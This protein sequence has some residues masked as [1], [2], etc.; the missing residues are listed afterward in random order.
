MRIE[1]SQP[2]DKEQRIRELEGKI[3]T[4]CMSCPHAKFVTAGQ[5]KCDRKRSQCHSKRVKHWL[6]ELKRFEG[7]D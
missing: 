6:D 4:I 2:P 3:V 1:T 5:F 7:G